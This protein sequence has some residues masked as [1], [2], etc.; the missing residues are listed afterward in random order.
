MSETISNAMKIYELQKK[1][2]Q[3][4]VQNKIIPEIQE[5]IRQSS[6]FTGISWNQYTPY[7]NDGEDCEFSITIGHDWKVKI[8]DKWVHIDEDEEGSPILPLLKKHYNGKD[9][10]TNLSY[11]QAEADI[12]RKIIDLVEPIGDF[13]K[14]IFD[15]HVSVYVDLNGVETEDYDHD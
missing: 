12:L 11:S 15:D 3:E 13:M 14:A 6:L 2:L 10:V 1:A 8:G 9:W 4:T 5:I 7:F